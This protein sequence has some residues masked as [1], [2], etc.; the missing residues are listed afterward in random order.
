MGLDIRLPIGM[1]FSLLGVLLCGY[2][3]FTKANADMYQHSLNININMVWGVVLVVFGLFMLISANIAKKAA[4]DG[5][6]K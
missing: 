1:M 6:A 5:K 3:F 2:G 4:G